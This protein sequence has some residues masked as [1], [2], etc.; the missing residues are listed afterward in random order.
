MRLNS[1]ILNLG[2][3]R[4]VQSGG[5]EYCVE[6]LTGGA[7]RI[8][9]V[10]PGGG[11]IRIIAPG[12]R[13]GWSA[14]S[15]ERFWVYADEKQIANTEDTLNLRDQRRR[16]LVETCFLALEAEAGVVADEKARQDAASREAV[17]GRP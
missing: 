13:P 16:Q 4:S 8:R 3:A 7:C 6:T 1:L 17:L 15:F 10:L 14:G 9:F 12:P 5:V 2:P 11:A